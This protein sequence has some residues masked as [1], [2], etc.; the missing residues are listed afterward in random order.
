ML[1][2]KKGLDFARN[3][4]LK[5]ASHPIIAF[6]DDDVLVD[7]DWTS[8][9]KTCFEN[10]L[11]MAVTGLVIPAELETESQYEFE[12]YWGFNKGYQPIV[13]DHT[14]FL[15]NLD[16]GVPVWEIGAGA[17]MAFPPRNI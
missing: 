10:P 1:E 11:T 6:T 9:I 12:K 8:H 3:A 2:E 15:K 5:V 16:I 14:F 7:T 13:F 17:N 4:G